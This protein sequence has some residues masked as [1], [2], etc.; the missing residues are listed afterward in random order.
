M[1]TLVRQIRF[2]HRLSQKQLGIILG[3]KPSRISAIENG[4]PMKGEELGK[5]L[6][7]MGKSIFYEVDPKI[8]LIIPSEKKEKL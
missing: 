4:R 5:I 1:E 7:A 8:R 6:N 3:V 2:N